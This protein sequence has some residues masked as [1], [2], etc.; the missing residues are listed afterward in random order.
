MFKLSRKH[1][2]SQ[3]RNQWKWYASLL[4][5][6]HLHPLV[7]SRGTKPLRRCETRCP[8]MEIQPS[9][10]S[11]SFPL[12]M[13][14]ES[15]W[16]VGVKTPSFKT[17]LSRMASNWRS[18]VSTKLL[19]ISYFYA[20]FARDNYHWNVS[21]FLCYKLHNSFGFPWGQTTSTGHFPSVSC[22]PYYFSSRLLLR[23]HFQ[24]RLFVWSSFVIQ[25]LQM[26]NGLM[27]H[28]VTDSWMNQQ[29][30]HIFCC[31]FLSRKSVHFVFSV[32]SDSN[33]RS[34]VTFVRQT[35]WSL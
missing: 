9:L 13:I 17:L 29:S 11:L 5:H 30:V 19:H 32:L 22:Y 28:R 2:R 4:D 8:W 20:A 33:S 18:T 26:Y 14:R 16:H 1:L 34:I 31:S 23:F 24:S 21:S 6:D 10:S 15:S 3:P 12:P 25:R 7:G 27:T 35:L